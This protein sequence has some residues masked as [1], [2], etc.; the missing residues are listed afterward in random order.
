[1]ATYT[2]NGTGFKALEMKQSKLDYFDNYSFL[3]GISG[4]GLSLMASNSDIHFSDWD[5]FLLIK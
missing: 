3:E 1:M 5:A 4:I 2:N